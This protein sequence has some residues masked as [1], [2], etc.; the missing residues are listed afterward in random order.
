MNSH[1]HVSE[2]LAQTLNPNLARE[3]EAAAATAAA[4]VAGRNAAEA[5]ASAFAQ[6]RA[7]AAVAEQQRAAAAAVAERAAKI[8]AGVAAF[9]VMLDR[10]MSG[11]S[12]VR[13]AG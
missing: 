10:R 7:A 3:L 8:D 9:D 4:A 12:Q 13:G 2:R 1:L 11:L 6:Q 5:A